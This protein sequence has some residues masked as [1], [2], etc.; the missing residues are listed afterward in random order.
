MQ[1]FYYKYYKYKLKY[2]NLKKQYGGTISINNIKDLTKVISIPRQVGSSNLQVVKDLV[3]NKLKE[4]N[5]ITQEQKFTETI[6]NTSFNFSNIIA[7]NPKAT[8]KYILLAA[9][10]D[11]CPIDNFEGAIDSASS[12]AII[13]ELAKNLLEI[14]PSYPL[15]ILF[16]DGEEALQGEWRTDNTLIG[17]KYFVNNYDISQI[18]QLYLL[19]LI[20]GNIEN[21]FY[22]FQNNILSYEQIKRLSD[23]NKKYNFDI[24]INPSLKVEQKEI[25]DDHIAFQ[26]KGIKYLHLI[27][28][29]FP[30]QH[31]KIIDNYENLNWK[32][33][34]VFTKVLF[35]YLIIIK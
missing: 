11:S 1:S 14:N 7:Y 25:Q 10:I 33:I 31:H 8:K 30:N 18:D 9:H 24:F 21:K 34:E 15:M 19:D 26:N 20:G 27:P 2:L 32:Y 6:K 23:I 16:F 35:E 29:P 5:L 28:T 13:L 12:I 17:S 3:I 4:L 22:A